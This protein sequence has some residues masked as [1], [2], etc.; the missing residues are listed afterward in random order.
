[1]QVTALQRDRAISP[2][3]TR[4]FSGKCGFCTEMVAIYF[5]PKIPQKGPATARS[6]AFGE[7]PRNRRPADLSGGLETLLF[8]I[9]RYP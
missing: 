3:G 9:K 7:F 8:L 5:L 2:N 1:M 6:C 4:E